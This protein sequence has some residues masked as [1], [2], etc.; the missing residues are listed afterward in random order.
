MSNVLPK[1]K[2]GQEKAKIM[3]M[4]LSQFWVQK[5]GWTLLHFLWQGTAI[6]VVYATL[7]GLLDRALGA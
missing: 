3:Q 2:S 1:I 4:F 7:R 6:A 5:L